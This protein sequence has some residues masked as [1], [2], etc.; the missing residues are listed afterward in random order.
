MNKIRLFV[1]FLGLLFINLNAQENN[2]LVF[3]VPVSLIKDW[4]ENKEFNLSLQDLENAAQIELQLDEDLLYD[5]INTDK[6]SV[7]ITCQA[8]TPMG[9]WIGSVP[10]PDY[11]GSSIPGG[12]GQVCNLWLLDDKSFDQEEKKPAIQQPTFGRRGLQA[13]Q[14][15]GY[16]ADLEDHLYVI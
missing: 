9:K 3:D 12:Q 6:L 5:W 2:V 11:K 13:L 14:Q 16:D 7:G 15:S 8:V 1:P 4:K 10:N